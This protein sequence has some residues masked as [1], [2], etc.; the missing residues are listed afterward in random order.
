M[1]T[2]ALLLGASHPLQGWAQRRPVLTTVQSPLLEHVVSASTTAMSTH[3]TPPSGLVVSPPPVNPPPLV[4][5]RP[6]SLHATWR[7]GI[8]ARATSSVRVR[9]IQPV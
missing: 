6:P 1:F 5:P 2:A 8:A 3:G 4:V 9:V 7:K